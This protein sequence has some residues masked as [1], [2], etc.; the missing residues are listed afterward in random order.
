MNELSDHLALRVLERIEE[1]VDRLGDELA[2]L[3]QQV[4]AL[5]EGLGG[6][7]Q[8]LERIEQPIDAAGHRL[9]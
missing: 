5:A 6:V 8:R 1:K 3:R 9:P 4:R 7:A 2:E